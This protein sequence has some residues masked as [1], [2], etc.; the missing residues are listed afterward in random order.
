MYE[1]ATYVSGVKQP[2]L[3]KS[4][5]E[6]RRVSKILSSACG[7]EAVVNPV[8]VI[9]AREL[10]LKGSPTQGDV[11]GRRKVVDWLCRRPTQLSPERIESIYSVACRRSTWAT[12]GSHAVG[13]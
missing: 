12:V 2:Y 10:V 7:F 4:R 5:A 3:S 13:A 6:G 8:V 11:V 1:Y 9:M